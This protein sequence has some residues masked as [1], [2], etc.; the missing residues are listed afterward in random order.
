MKPDRPDG[1][2]AD[3]IEHAHLRD[4]SDHSHV[5]H[6]YPMPAG[7]EQLAQRFWIPVWS[8]PPGR[9]APQQVLQYPVGL[10]VIAPGYAR[11]YGVT[12]GLLTT[13]L[14]GDGWAVGIMLQPAGGA[15]V[16]GG[17]MDRWTDRFGDLA[18]LLGDAGAQ[19]TRRVRGAMAADPG[20]MEAHRAAMDA[21]AA[22]L[23]DFLPV[24]PEG[25]F[26]NEL[27]GFVERSPE[28]T[29]VA[30]VCAEF[31]LTER[32]LQRLC[33]RRLGLTPKWLIQRRRLQEGAQR[34][35][36]G[37]G[38]LVD[39]AADLGYADQP[40]FTRDFQ[41]VTGMTPGEFAARHT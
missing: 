26:V 4:P 27:V 32:S 11:F 18:E 1:A 10:M 21:F 9:T 33:R 35:R 24:D 39:V 19:L 8:V 12:P 37:R 17:P 13:V 28:V 7:L 38:S 36:E 31:T 29:R 20:A 15:L 25:L 14:S 16:S 34:L 41:A 22:L 5:I 2:E 23:R 40:H 6:R 3:R 30:Q